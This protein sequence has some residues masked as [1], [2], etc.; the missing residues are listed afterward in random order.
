M[1]FTE[2]YAKILVAFVSIIVAIIPI[3]WS[4]IQSRKIKQEDL[5]HRERHN[6][7]LFEVLSNDNH[8][9]QLA[10]ASLLIERL[11]RPVKTLDD[12]AERRSILRALISVTKDAPSDYK[13]SGIS[14]ELRKF[15][16]DNIVVQLDSF[17]NRK[18]KK[19]SN[20][21]PMKEF[22]WQNAHLDRAWWPSIDARGVDFWH[23][24]LREI[25]MS[26]ADLSGAILKDANLENSVLKNA[27][28]QNA[29]LRGANLI[30]T[31]LT[32]A[33][34]KNARL[35]NAKYDSQTTK[36]SDDFDLANTGMIASV[37][38]QSGS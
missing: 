25:G 12:K 22:D 20:L 16:A 37:A 19:R 21:S 29:D 5:F 35:S 13:D 17:V 36:F 32:G 38:E 34:F 3:L 31:D 9:L 1:V 4:W 30:G 6:L 24:S 14:P 15:V 10:A 8:R 7:N 18:S 23:A 11:K 27:I 33:D 26:G 28:L 2:S